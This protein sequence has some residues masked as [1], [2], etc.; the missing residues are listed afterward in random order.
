MKTHL[1]NLNSDGIWDDNYTEFFHNRC[2]TISE[3]LKKRIIPRDI[4]LIGQ[5]VR[6]HDLEELGLEE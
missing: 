4:D 1:I 3:E 5:P 2:E 6:S